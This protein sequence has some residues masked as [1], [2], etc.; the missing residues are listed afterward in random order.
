MGTT[1]LPRVLV[2]RWYVTLTGLA[3][4]LLLCAGAHKAV[5]ATY[6]ASA[7][8]LLVPPV[9]KV[10]TN[11]YLELSGLEQIADVVSRAAS[12]DASA[13]QLHDRGF[14]GKYA[15]ARDQ[16]V[17]GPM[18]LVTGTG[19]TPAAALAILRAATDLIPPR[20]QELQ[21]S[22]NVSPSAM[23]NS[24]VIQTADK[25]ATISKSQTRATFGAAAVGLLITFFGVIG[26]ERF[27]QRRKVRRAAKRVARA[28][29]TDARQVASAEDA[30][31]TT[32]T[33]S[34]EREPLS[35]VGVVA[36]GSPARFVERRASPRR[37]ADRH[38]APHTADEN[39]HATG[40][41]VKRDEHS[42]G[43]TGTRR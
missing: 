36:E 17:S 31:G 37:R 39:P 34:D 23:L 8:V 40:V 22:S 33:S 30:D 9:T 2:R 16:T 29:E 11:P 32:S 3:L 13:Q 21:S 43:R 18:I 38:E 35:N 6:Q 26:F 1:A 28:A 25:A 19:P 42:F 15:I 24:K 4:T 27:A 5:P 41:M 7:S 20:L 12:D 10:G 14:I